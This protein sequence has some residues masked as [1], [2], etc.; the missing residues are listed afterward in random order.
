MCTPAIRL[1]IALTL[2]TVLEHI[3]KDRR[4]EARHECSFKCRGV[5]KWGNTRSLVFD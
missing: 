3:F 4:G 2:K 1:F 5:W